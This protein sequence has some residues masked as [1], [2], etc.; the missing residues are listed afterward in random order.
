[1]SPSSN[2][3]PQGNGLVESTNKNV[4]KILKK[5]IRKNQKDWY[6][7]LHEALWEDIITPKVAIGYSPF[8]L[9]YGR[10][11]ILPTNI[12]LTALQLA[13]FDIDNLSPI[14]QRV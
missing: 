6:I 1:M 10:E 5:I 13:K 7:K 14:E 3:Y 9:V 12:S 11:A 8:L 4:I 2:Y